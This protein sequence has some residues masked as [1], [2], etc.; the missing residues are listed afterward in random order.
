MKT[1]TRLL[2]T[3]LLL[4]SAESL[5]AEGNTRFGFEIGSPRGE[6]NSSFAGSTAD[7]LGCSGITPAARA[8][9]RELQV[10]SD[11]GETGVL[12]LAQARPADG[13]VPVQ[14]ATSNTGRFWVMDSGEALD[15]GQVIFSA[16][17]QRAAL[18]VSQT[19]SQLLLP[20]PPVEVTLASNPGLEP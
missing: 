17:G 19:S 12:E 13:Y 11:S 4:V 18:N 15:Y 10:G 3:T 1:L 9:A 8:V 14:P 2:A 6:C 5:L 7:A 16:L 20:V